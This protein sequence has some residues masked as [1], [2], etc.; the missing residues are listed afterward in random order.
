MVAEG[1]QLAES[2]RGLV[3]DVRDVIGIDQ[4][5]ASEVEVLLAAR[6]SR[7][8]RSASLLGSS[9]LSS[10]ARAV[11]SASAMAADRIERRE[12]QCLLRLG[13]LDVGHRDRGLVASESELDPEM[14]VDDMAGRPVDQDLGDPAD[15]G[16]STGQGSLLVGRVGAPVARVRDEV[17]WRNLGVVDDPGFASR[18]RRWRSRRFLGRLTGRRAVDQEEAFRS[19]SSGGAIPLAPTRTINRYTRGSDSKASG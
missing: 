4:S 18:A 14:P 19:L 12:D 15:L 6:S 17:S 10:A 11:A 1:V 5:G 8:A 9:P 3:R 13:Q 16:E 7:S 2:D